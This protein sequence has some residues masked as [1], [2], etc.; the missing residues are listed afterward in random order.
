MP[1]NYGGRQVAFV[2]YELPQSGKYTIYARED[3]GDMT[4]GYWLSLHCRETLRDNAL[5]LPYD[6]TLTSVAISPYGDVDAYSFTGQA[7]EHV[8][9]RL[10]P[11]GIDTYFRGMLELY[12]PSDSLLKS[13]YDSWTNPNNPYNYGGRQ[14]AFVDY[15][16]PQSGKYTI[17]ARE[18]NGDMTSGYWLSLH[19]RETLR[20][21][22]LALPYDT[23]LT[24]VAISPYGDVDAYSFTGQAG[25]HVIIR[26]DPDG[27]DTYFRGILELYS[28]SD[29]LLKSAYDSWT[30]P[31][32]PY[33]YGGRQVA[34]VDYEL[35]QSGKYTIYA[36]EDNGDMTS[37]YWLSL[38][39]RETLR[40]NAL[41]LPYDTT[42]TS[43]A[44]SPY[45]DVDAYSFT[46]QAGEHVI[47]RLDPDGIDTYFRGMLELY[48]PSDSLLKSAYD[49]WTN[50]NNPYNYGGR[51]VA[52]VDYELPQSGKYTIYARE[53]NGDMTSGYWLSLHC[54][55]TLRDNALALP[56]DTTLTSVA[57]SPYGDVDAYSFTGQAGEHVIIR[58]DPDGIDTYFRGMLELYSPSD[59]LLKS[60]YDSWTNPNN[61]Y[62]YGGRQVAFV[63]YELPQSGKYTIYAR[64]DNGDMTSGYWLSLHCRETILSNA[65]TLS[66]LQGDRQD[67]LR[68]YGDLN[69]YVFLVDENDSTR[70]V[71]TSLS[72]GAEPDLELYGP[73]DSLVSRT[74]GGTTAVV[75]DAIFIKSGI[76][77]M[78]VGDYGSDEFGRYQFTW[79]GIRPM[80]MHVVRHRLPA[81]LTGAFFT[82]TF[83]AIGGHSPYTWSLAS[84]TL[85]VG[86]SLSSDGVL[87]GSTADTGKFAFVVRGD[88]FRGCDGDQRIHS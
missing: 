49:S 39:C 84:G 62:N 74:H 56:Y 46:G 75:E 27:I 6:T 24:S 2:D 79:T 73:G 59:S 37:G 42:L 80:A 52:F 33:N 58:L 17:Y 31:N 22:A 10:D 55:E 88:G 70:F 23:T 35:P 87:D 18:D 7:G 9:I 63:D 81:I 67:T 8:I 61:P 83:E 57:I 38:H 53:D 1:Y 85:P 86:F 41:A 29:S 20:D 44:I 65:D 4:S 5:A 12:S 43:V 71:V 45:G 30:N 64:E 19:C 21:N 13:A 47:I 54:R 15:E 32:N 16:L 51:Q 48:S 68:I 66:L 11:D 14:V 26:L 28:P 36:R 40:D 69:A 76:Y 50:P 78:F 34:F 82:H 3:N 77:K 60:A 72:G 25:E